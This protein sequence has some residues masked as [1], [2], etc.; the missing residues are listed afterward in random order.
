MCFGLVVGDHCKS[1]DTFFGLLRISDPHIY[2]EGAMLGVVLSLFLL[3]FH[4]PARHGSQ[5]LHC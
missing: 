3:A 5:V 2:L 1:F 4:N